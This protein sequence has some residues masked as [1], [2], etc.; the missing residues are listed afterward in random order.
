MKQI[1]E[2]APESKSK[3]VTI[4]NILSLFRICLIPLIVW[5]YCVE[6][7]DLWA[8][9][10]LLLS[11][12]TDIA[13]G[14]IARR[15]SMVSDL[16]KALDPVADKLTQ[17]AMLICLLTRFPLILCPLLLMAVKEVFMGAAGLL[18]IRK[19]GNVPAAVWH[20][21]AATFLLYAMILVHLFWSG[22]PAA[23]SAVFIG[24]CTAMIGISFGLY[25]FRYA[26]ILGKEKANRT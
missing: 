6:K 20:G 4:P 3:I 21:K 24:A 25:A 12:A 9:G 7:R 17:A 18:L 11:G 1:S 22:I 5:L 8:G 15:F 19:T 10:I 2:H 23:V 16:G 14:Y 26:R 13:D